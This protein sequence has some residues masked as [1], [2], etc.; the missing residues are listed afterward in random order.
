[1]PAIDFNRLRREI[2]MQDVLDL[3]GFQPANR[4]GDQVHGP[5]P[6]HKSTSPGAR[7]F[8]ANLGSGRYY[9]H[10]CHSC[11]NQLELWG[12]VRGLLIYD[13][14]LDL[15][16]ALGREVPWLITGQQRRGTGNPPADE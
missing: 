8:S 1:M 9:C 5:C 7:T 2:P 12:A 10:K 13:A 3:L 11:G 4:R 6:V 14:S 15:C 16:H